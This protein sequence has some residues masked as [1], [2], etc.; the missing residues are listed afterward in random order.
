MTDFFETRVKTWSPKKKRKN[1]QQMPRNSWTKVHHQKESRRL[2]QSVAESRKIKFSGASY[3][4][5]TVIILTS[6][7]TYVLW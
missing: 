1:L 2:Q 3:T 4:V 5:K 6:T 7:K